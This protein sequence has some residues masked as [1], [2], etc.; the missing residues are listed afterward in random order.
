MGIA[1][2][3]GIMLLIF[4]FIIYMREKGPYTFLDDIHPGMYIVIGAVVLINCLVHFL[5]GQRRRSD[6]V[7]G[8][9]C[10]EIPRRVA[11]Y[12]GDGLRQDPSFPP[13]EWEEKEVK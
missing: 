4:G 3:I 2:T 8:P 7:L 9:T 12:P 11:L 13:Q 6:V 1:L 5:L 10:K